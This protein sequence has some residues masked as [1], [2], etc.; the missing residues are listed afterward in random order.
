VVRPASAPIATRI[1]EFLGGFAPWR[2]AFA[3]LRVCLRALRGFAVFRTAVCPNDTEKRSL[4]SR[5]FQPEY[6][7]NVAEHREH[8]RAAHST[9]EADGYC[10]C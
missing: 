2:D 9:A 1:K 10:H 7:P 8:G 6:R 5:F 4:R 3:L